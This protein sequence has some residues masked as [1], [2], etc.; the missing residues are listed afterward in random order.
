MQRIIL[1]IIGTLFVAL[2]LIGI[3]LPLLPTTP[4]LLAA[5]AC[6]AKSSD[7]LYNWLLNNRW[8]GTYIRNW[9]EG[10][11]LPLRTKI[12]ALSLLFLTIGYSVLYVVPLLVIRILLVII[13][14]LVSKHIYSFPTLKIN[15]E[16]LS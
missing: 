12:L 6:Y 7:R 1:I 11:G 4:F 13:A 2:G 8:F 16:V 10:K 14:L 9:R 5:A 15:E 3:L